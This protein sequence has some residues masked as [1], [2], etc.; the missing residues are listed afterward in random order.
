M[1]STFTSLHYHVVFSTKERQ[2]LIRDQW[3]TTLHSWLGGAVRTLGG[4]ALS[5]GGVADHIHMLL[6]LR[7]THAIADILRDI[8]SA[9]SDWVHTELKDRNFFWQEG[10]GAFTV[11]AS[12]LDAVRNYIANQEEHHRTKSFQDEY[13]ALLRRHGIK[14]DERYLW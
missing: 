1:P 7:T 6:G 11:S 2:R 10:Y 8:K 3:R 14:F 13:R 4:V 12:S 9:S 5:I